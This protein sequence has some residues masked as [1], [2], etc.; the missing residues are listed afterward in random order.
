LILTM[1]A[2]LTLLTYEFGVR[3]WSATRLLFG[4]SP[5]PRI[6]S[7]AAQAQRRRRAHQLV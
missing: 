1:V 5:A 2:A 7:E 4:L 6:T 3:R